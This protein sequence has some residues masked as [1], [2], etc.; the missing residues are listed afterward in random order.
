MVAVPLGVLKRGTPRFSPGLPHDRLAAIARLGFGR[1]EKVVLAFAQPFWRSAGLS[2]LL[3]FPREP[4]EPTMWIFDH[5][6]FGTGPVLE[7]HVFHS[8]THH[9]VDEPRAVD[10]VLS[11]LGQ[12]LGGPCPPP[13]AVAVTSW[14]TDPWSGGAYTH[15]TPGASPADADLLGQPVG[16]RLLFAGEHTQS[17]RLGYADGAMSSGLR[18]AARLLGS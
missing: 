14:S 2:H 12:A 9:V 17:A 10:W 1:Y 8:A 13:T 16:D 4:D 3:V 18:E 7:C 6:A 5:D 15:V 11:L